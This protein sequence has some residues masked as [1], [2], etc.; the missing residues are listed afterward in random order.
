MDHGIRLDFS[1]NAYIHDN[2]FQ[3]IATTAILNLNTAG[4][5]DYS[6]I[7]RNWFNRCA[8]AI[9]LLDASN[10]MIHGNI[11]NGDG[12]GTNNFINLTG[13]SNN[14]VADNYLSCTLGAEYNLTCSDATSGS[15]INNHCENGPTILPPT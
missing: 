15:W 5:P 3:D 7:Y 9:V 1:Y 4:D 11:I 14:V 6:F 13:G 12:G 2:T 8:A 10:C